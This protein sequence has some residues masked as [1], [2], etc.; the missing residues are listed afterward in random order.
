ME[1]LESEPLSLHYPELMLRSLLMPF[2]PRDGGEKHRLSYSTSQF[3]H[4]NYTT[5]S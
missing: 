1:M 5:E 2:S 3:F 4:N